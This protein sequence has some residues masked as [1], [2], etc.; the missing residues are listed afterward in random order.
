MTLYTRRFQSYVKNEMHKTTLGGGELGSRAIDV[1]GISRSSGGDA[2]PAI[3]CVENVFGDPWYDAAY[4]DDDPEFLYAQYIF[5][6]ARPLTAG[7][8]FGYEFQ[9]A[10]VMRPSDLAR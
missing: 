8:R 10:V 9:G 5:G 1:H 7:I 6:P 3:A 2:E 4:A